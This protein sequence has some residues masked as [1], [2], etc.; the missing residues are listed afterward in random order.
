MFNNVKFSRDGLRV[1]PIHDNRHELPDLETARE[2]IPFTFHIP[3][4]GIAGLTYTWVNKKGEA[5]AAMALSGPGI[6]DKPIAQLLPDRKIPDTMDF[7]NWEIDGFQMQQ[8]LHFKNAKVR[9]EAPE[10]LLEFDFEA[11]HPPYA[12]SSH[13]DGCP[14]YAAHDRIEQSGKCKGRIVLGNREIHFDSFAHRDHSWGTRDWR[15]FQH[16][17]WFHGQ[18]PDGK[19][20][21]HYWRCLALGREIIRGYIFQDNTM[22]E[23]TKVE[24]DMMYDDKLYQQNLECQIH[25]ELGRI[26]DVTADF[27]THYFLHPSPLWELREGAATATF[28]GQKA[29]V[30]VECG[31]PPAYLDG[32]LAA[33]NDAK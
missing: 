30:W 28:N 26:I 9:W 23:I 8:D 10:V 19:T 1:D 20:A 11:I 14:P 24:S 17:N 13:P 7:S 2:S 29:I 31:W 5:G 16:Y 12:Y 3:E 18:T 4:L 21:I 6:G 32:V 25:D 27:Y 22:A 33:V 15:Y